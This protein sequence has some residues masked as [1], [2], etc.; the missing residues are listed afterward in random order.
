MTTLVF[1][2]ELVRRFPREFLISV[3][4]LLV[5]GGLETLT[6]L[7]L[8]P[9]VDLFS[10]QSFANVGPV[11]RQ[12]MAV[13]EWAGVSPTLAHMMFV[14]MGLQFMSSALSIIAA[15]SILL[16]KYK[17]INELLLGSFEEFFAARWS[18]FSSNSQGALLNTFT[19]AINQVGDAFSGIGLFLVVGTR[20][21]S[22]GLV[23]L[24]ISWRITLFCVGLAGLAAWP[25]LRL[26]KTSYRL[27][28]INTETANE[29]MSLLQASLG[30]AKVVLGFGNQKKNAEVLQRSYREHCRSTILFQTLTQAIPSAYKPLGLGILVLALLLSRHWGVSLS[31]IGVMMLA[32]LQMIP[33]VGQ[34]IAN[35]SSVQNIIPAYEQIEGLRREAERLKQPT[36]HRPF[37]AFEKEV[38]FD[39]VSFS[40]PDRPPLLHEINLRIRKGQFIAIVGESGVGKSTLVD[41]VMTL[42]EPTHGQITV[43]GVPLSEFEVGSYRQRIG[44]VPQ[45]SV[46]FNASIRENLLWAKA[47]ASGEDIRSACRRANAAEFIDK[48]PQG[49]ETVIGDRGVRLSGGQAQR[50]SL[51]RAILRNPV[52]LI[53]DEATSALDTQSERLIQHAVESLSKE[54]TL[55][56]IAHRLSTIVN[57]DN[58][59]LLKDGRVAEEGAYPALMKR[60]GLF[61]QMVHLQGLK[62]F[63]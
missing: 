15:R 57:A 43:D 7:T 63:L 34:L 61:Y 28:Q 3:L 58:I 44:Y 20:L 8:V 19:R 38:I 48:L 62:S 35:K 17:V 29:L 30:G 12:F 25:F 36:G 22:Y 50:V 16:I 60:K 32:F 5:S 49:Y 41:L 26:G 21:V 4:L 9:V 47:D 13:F 6:L 27:G 40:Y 46:L 56:A 33:Q 10:V 1:I 37:V 54:T 45:E 51:A 18:F 52:L 2:R 39:N 11:T 53:L 24:A 42:H 14:L 59:I 31:E 23:P 55:I